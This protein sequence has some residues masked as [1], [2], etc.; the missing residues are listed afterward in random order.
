MDYFVAKQP[1]VCLADAEMYFARNWPYRETVT[2]TDTRTSFV[3]NQG[4]FAFWFG[5]SPG[6]VN[7]WARPER[8]GT[9]LSVDASR[10]HYSR[11]IHNWLINGLGAMPV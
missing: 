2:R 8:G 6:G 10:G 7:V 4:C 11:T 1:A 3:E 5:G 9:R